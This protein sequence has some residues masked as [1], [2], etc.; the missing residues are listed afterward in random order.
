ML[1]SAIR[2]FTDIVDLSTHTHGQWPGLPTKV[3]YYEVGKLAF[4]LLPILLS[5]IAALGGLGVQEILVILQSHPPFHLIKNDPL[6]LEK[7]KTAQVIEW[8]LKV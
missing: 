8:F 6:E 7:V 3:T 4:D 5:R 1:N 2:D